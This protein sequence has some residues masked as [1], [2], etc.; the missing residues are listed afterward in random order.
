VPWR[1]TSAVEERLRF[2]ADYLDGVTTMTELAAEYGISR[3]TGYTW[4]RRYEAEGPAGLHDRSRRPH[5]V[6]NA[7]PPAV[8][9]ALL[10]AR[11]RHP[12]WGPKK[13]LAYDWPLEERPA[14]S[15]ASAMLKRAG[16]V[17]RRRRRRRPGHPGRPPAVIAAPN[18]LWSIDFK[19]QFKTSDG[20]WCYPLTILDS[21]SRYVLACHGLRSTATGG[22]RGVLE[23]VFREYGL[24]ERIR[25]DNGVPFATAWAAA[26]LSALAVWWVHLGIVPELIEPGRPSQNGR[27]ERF[28]RTLKRETAQPPAA[29]CRAQQRRFTTFCDEFNH[30]RPHE[31]LG[32]R[33]PSAV[34]VASRREYPRHL[35]ALSYPADSTV[36]RVDASGSIRWAVG[37]RVYISHVLTGEDIAFRPIDDGKWAVY[38]GPIAL[39]HYDER[40]GPTTSLAPISRGRSPANA[41]S[42]PKVKSSIKCQPCP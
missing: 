12:T 22:A 2:V 5:R 7:T 41:A 14:L 20:Q 3:E 6:G 30:R 25:S 16:L 13:L 4:V 35:P 8:I 11:R 32:Q 37:T 28:H 24:P 36:R 15:T 21:C 42:R 19:G 34:Y 39:G 33:V 38:F 27:H 1:T 23:R 9:D 26:R 18:V 40:R 10:A 17:D 31:A 29:T